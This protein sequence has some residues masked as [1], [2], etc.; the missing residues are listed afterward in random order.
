MDIYALIATANFF[1]QIVVL[2]LLFVG[3]WFK[4]RKKFR[5]HCITM[6]SAVCFTQLPYS[7]L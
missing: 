7:R 2:M 6:L 1:L 3:V 4:M 5:Q